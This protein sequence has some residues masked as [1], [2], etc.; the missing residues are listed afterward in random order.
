MDNHTIEH[1][2]KTFGLDGCVQFR[3]DN[4]MEK[5][6]VTACGS[7]LE[8]YLHGAHI[9]SYVP[10]QGEEILWLSPQAIYQKGKAI[11][12]GIPLC[13]PWFGKHSE[14]GSL[15]QHGFARN[16]SFSMQYAKRLANGAVELLLYLTDNEET[17]ELWPHHFRLEV[18]IILGKQLSID[19][20]T[21]NT[22][23]NEFVITEAI[24]S[25]FAVPDISNAVV[26]GLQNIQYYDQLQDKQETEVDDN[27]TISQEVDRIYASQDTPITIA[28][29]SNLR[30]EL[31]QEKAN[32]TVLWNPW[33]DKSCN[34]T[35]FPDDGY[36]NMLCV[37]AANT[38][39]SDIKIKSGQSH[40]IQQI[41][42]LL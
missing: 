1:L 19:M 6:V 40:S 21:H 3:K 32:A 4:D 42:K 20:I 34:M 16:S 22:G 11:R 5:F 29:Q 12:G 7:K 24:H 23:R 2:N 37:E 10:Q 31:L 39:F 28:A 26:N 13:W 35:D 14:N 8:G 27:I 41:I 33:I 18:K 30:I 15:P 9:T 25:Y 17:L 38:F 36:K